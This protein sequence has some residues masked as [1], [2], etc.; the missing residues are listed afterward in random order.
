MY[1]CIFVIYYNIHI[2]ICTCTRTY[3]HNLCE[4]E[5]KLPPLPPP[6]QPTLPRRLQEKKCYKT[7]SSKK[8]EQHA[9][10]AL[11]PPSQHRLQT[12]LY[13]H[14]HMYMYIIY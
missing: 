12:S 10:A 5:P 4:E 6:S 7:S 13:I 11:P 9:V 1:I 8:V 2:Y 3:I 14:V